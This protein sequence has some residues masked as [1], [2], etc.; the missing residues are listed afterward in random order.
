M[1]PSYLLPGQEV[2]IL[3]DALKAWRGQRSMSQAA[4]AEAASCSE[5]LIALIET[6]RRQPGLSNALAISRAL[7]VPLR[8]FALVHVDLD[9]MTEAVA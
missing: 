9:A 8:V 1:L 4:L 2:T 6:G 5:G 3:P 7:G